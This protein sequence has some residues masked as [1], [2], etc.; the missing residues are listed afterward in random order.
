MIRRLLRR[1]FRRGGSMPVYRPA[2][3]ERIVTLSPGWVS[4]EVARHYP[5]E[6]IERLNQPRRRGEQ[7]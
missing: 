6:F 7:P 4:P 1:M 2:E 5:P 3:G